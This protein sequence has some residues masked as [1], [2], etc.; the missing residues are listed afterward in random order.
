MLKILRKLYLLGGR[1]FLVLNPVPICCYS[2]DSSPNSLDIDSSGCM[3]SFND[4]VKFNSGLKEARK[5][6]RNDLH[7]GNVMYIDTHSLL[8][9]PLSTP[10]VMRCSRRSE[11]AVTM[12]VA[13]NIST[14]KFSAGAQKRLMER[15][16]LSLP[17]VIL[18]IM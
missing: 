8:L 5:Q 1:T 15:R 13:L 16:L 4:A 12:V 14:G 2:S 11:H 6:T 3:T 18:R 7:N 10:H 9:E 17:A